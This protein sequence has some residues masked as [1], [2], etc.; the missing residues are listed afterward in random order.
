MNTIKWSL[1]DIKSLRPE[2]SNQ[3]CKEFIESKWESFKQE[4]IRQ[5]WEI[6]ESLLE[7]EKER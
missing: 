4:S 5:G 2:W 6:W 1:E 3:E 7:G